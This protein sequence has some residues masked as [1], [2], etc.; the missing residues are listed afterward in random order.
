MSEESVACC[1]LA[2]LLRACEECEAASIHLPLPPRT[3]S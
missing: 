3:I 2:E 1:L